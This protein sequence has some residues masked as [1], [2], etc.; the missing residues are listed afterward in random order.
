MRR[1]VISKT[2]WCVLQGKRK[3]GKKAEE[4]PV[5]RASFRPGGL[6]RWTY[7]K[8]AM[9]HWGREGSGQREQHEQRA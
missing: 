9:E 2:R 1:K 8:S 3:Q 5:G 4:V 7:E 6:K